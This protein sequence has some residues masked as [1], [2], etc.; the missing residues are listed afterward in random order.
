MRASP[1]DIIIQPVIT[2][3]S[4]AESEKGRYTF[5][6]RT[7][8]TKNEIRQA[9]EQIYKVEVAKVNTMIVKGKRRRQGRLPAGRTAA[10][11]KAI[12]RLKPGHKIEFLEA[13]E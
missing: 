12:V 8:A 9:I 6:V 3:K 2:E 1:Y 7:D 11:K 5:R 13:P 4:V 10:W